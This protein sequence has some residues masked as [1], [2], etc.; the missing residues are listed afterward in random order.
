[1]KTYRISI[2]A[3]VLGVSIV[4][5]A[6]AQPYYGYQT[7]GKHTFHVSIVWKDGPWFGVGYTNRAFGQTFT[8]WQAEWRFPVQKMYDLDNHEVLAGFYRPLKIRKNFLAMGLHGKLTRTTVG[9]EKRQQYSAAFTL[10]PSR[11]YTS[12]LSNG[13]YGTLGA[14]VT[15]NP[16]LL[17]RVEDTSTGQIT[18]Q[19]MAGHKIQVGGHIDVHLKRTFGGSTNVY[20]EKTF[21]PVSTVLGQTDDRWTPAWDVNMGTTYYLRRWGG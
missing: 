9:F 5:H 11:V 19:T 12:S 3:L 17:A 18:S 14:R 15:Y 20:Y 16:I 7:I 1:M 6:E 4:A 8:D 10:L 13:P 2:L 21:K